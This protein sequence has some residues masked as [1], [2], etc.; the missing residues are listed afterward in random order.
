[1]EAIFSHFLKA[2][3]NYLN[4]SA[5]YGKLLKGF[6][7]FAKRYWQFSSVNCT[8]ICY[9]FNHSGLSFPRCCHTLKA[10]FWRTR[11]PWISCRRV[12]SSRRRYKPSR[13]W[14]SPMKRRSTRPEMATS[15]WLSIQWHCSSAS[16]NCRTLIECINIPWTGSSVC[17]RTPSRKPINRRFSVNVWGI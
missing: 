3:I 10:I 4:F 9:V 6:L 5:S 7:T 16:N 17:S 13:R 11:I 15:Q 2:F 12:K 1:M 14:P 8:N